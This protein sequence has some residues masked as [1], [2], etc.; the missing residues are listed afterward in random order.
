MKGALGLCAAVL[1]LSL[2]AQTPGNVVTNVGYSLPQPIRV[3]PGQVVTL[4]VRNSK[5]VLDATV[6]AASLPLPLDLAGFSVGLKQTFSNGSPIAVPLFSVVP[7][8]NCS[9]VVPPVCANLTALTIQIPFE[10]VPNI[11]NSRLPQNFA[12]LVVSENGVE[13]DPVLLDAAPDRIHILN[14]CDSTAPPT[15]TCLP[16]VLHADR[17]TVT[18]RNPAHADELLFLQAYGLGRPDT[19]PI[20][21]Q[22]SPTPAVDGPETKVYFRFEANALPGKTGDP[23]IADSSQLLPGAVGVY[24]IGFRVPA[25]PDDLTPCSLEAKSNLTI[26]IVRGT[27]LD[28]AGICVE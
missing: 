9:G 12:T 1:S 25:L 16:V 4:F 14:S 10:L 8:R 13:G 19:L 11:P 2:Y 20:T 7:L 27:S 23:S 15:G 18:L 26:S 28:G 5:I 24:Q 21:G 22:A 6:S 3:A 17:S